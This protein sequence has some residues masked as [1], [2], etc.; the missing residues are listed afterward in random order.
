[1]RRYLLASLLVTVGLAVSAC[2]RKQ[3]DS[4]KPLANFTV[5]ARAQ[6]VS[7]ASS[8]Q[9]QFGTPAQA[10]TVGGGGGKV[11]LYVT[12]IFGGVAYET[13]IPGDKCGECYDKIVI[14][15]L[16]PEACW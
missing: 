5:V 12:I 10:V 7:G 1:M 6:Y 2:D 4:P 15:T 3:Q 14:G 8:P 11:G 16:L 9:P 13:S